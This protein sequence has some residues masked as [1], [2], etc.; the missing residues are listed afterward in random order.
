[1]NLPVNGQHAITLEDITG[2]NEESNYVVWNYELPLERR[3]ELFKY[4]M[5]KRY[6]N[7]KF[8]KKEIDALSDISFINSKLFITLCREYIKKK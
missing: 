8:T 6:P 2:I 4:Y 5:K 7:K 3:I 1:M